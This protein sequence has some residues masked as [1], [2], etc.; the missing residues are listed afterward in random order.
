MKDSHRE[1]HRAGTPIHG[2]DAEV[3]PNLNHEVT[4]GAASQQACH[5]AESAVASR[6]DVFQSWRLLCRT[7]NTMNRA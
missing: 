1:P 7:T 3:N 4:A 2:R 6:P 5:E